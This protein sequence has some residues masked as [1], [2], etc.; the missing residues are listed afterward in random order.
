MNNYT[1]DC[2]AKHWSSYPDPACH[3]E[4]VLNRQGPGQQLHHIDRELVTSHSKEKMEELQTAASPLLG[5]M[6][7]IDGCIGNILA[8]Y[9]SNTPAQTLQQIHN[10]L[11][12]SAL[13]QSSNLHNYTLQPVVT[14][15]LL[16]CLHTNKD[17]C[18]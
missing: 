8:A 5:I 18:H 16:L 12:T 9:V 17:N 1:S 2:L 3:T 13:K 6:W 15:P 4:I 7:C 14:L 11:G 10:L